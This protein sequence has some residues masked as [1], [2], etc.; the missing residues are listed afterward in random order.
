MFPRRVYLYTRRYSDKNQNCQ[1]SKKFDIKSP[2][3]PFIKKDKPRE[4]FKPNTP[5]S[6]EQ[7]KFHRC[8]GIGH[9]A[10]NCLEKEKINEIVETEDHNVKE[11]ESDS[12]KD[13]EESDT[14]ECDQINIIIS[15]ID[16][17]D[18]I[19]EVLD[20]KSS[21]PQIGTSDTNLTNIQYAK[22]YRTKPAKAM[23]YTA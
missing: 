21:L 19:Y 12:E 11:E 23:G 16:N 22:L 8:G 7:R 6:N 14:S 18:L 1:D 17:I 2:N 4:P 15:Q 9:L 10:N 5:N 20:A 13:T 3:K